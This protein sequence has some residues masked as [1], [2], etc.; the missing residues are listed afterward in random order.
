MGHREAN[1][2]DAE[3]AITEPARREMTLIQDGD[4][5]ARSEMQPPL[6]V[7][8]HMWI[9]WKTMVGTKPSGCRDVLLSHAN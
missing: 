4:W 7:A 1:K 9:Q 3:K 2:D 5:D 6:P 8:P